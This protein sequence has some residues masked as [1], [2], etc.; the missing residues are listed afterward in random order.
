MARIAAA[1]ANLWLLDEPTVAL[2]RASVAALEAAVAAHLDGGGIVVLSS[3][4]DVGLIDPVV[5]RIDDFTS[6][7]D[8]HM[9]GVA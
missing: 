2:D 5:L 1:P 8:S 9:D 6:V 7:D 3:N 4:V